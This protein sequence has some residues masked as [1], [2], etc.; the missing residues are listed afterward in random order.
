LPGAGLIE[1]V[2]ILQHFA[3]LK[4]NVM[5]LLVLIKIIDILW[6]NIRKIITRIPVRKRNK[7]M[8]K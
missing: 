6:Q 2:N 5:I 3:I 8:L 1:M 7:T 4:A